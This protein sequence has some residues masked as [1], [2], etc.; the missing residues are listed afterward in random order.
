M[1]DFLLVI[2]SNL[3]PI[4]HRFRD[5]ASQRSKIA[6]FFLTLFGLTPRRRVPWDDLRK[7][8]PGCR[9]VTN[10][11]HG[12]EALPKISIGWVGCTNVTDRRQTDGRT[13]IYSEYE[14]E[15]TFAKNGSVKAIG[16]SYV[17]C[18]VSDVKSSTWK[19]SVTDHPDKQLVGWWPY[20]SQSPWATRVS[21]AVNWNPL[22]R[23]PAWSY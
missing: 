17:T 4:L 21:A 13:T 6:T 19:P 12:A 7:I 14:H 16:Y 1:C 20:F 11:L 9:Q 22:S 8:L 2:N 23:T 3:P 5:I 10:V 18:G 15:F